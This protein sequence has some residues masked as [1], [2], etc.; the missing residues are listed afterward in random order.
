MQIVIPTR[1]RTNQQLTLQS[2]PRELLKQTTVVCPKNEAVSLY[3]LYND[4]QIVVQPDANW[5]IARK[6]AWIMRTWLAAGYDKIL[7]FDDDLTFATRITEGDWHLR[8]IQGEEL[9]AEIQRLEQKLGPAFPHV[10]FGQRQGNNNVASG[11]Q[12]PARMMYSLGY[13][14]PIVINECE[15]G[16]IETRE[17]MDITLQLLRKG[18]PN[19]VW[20]TTVS[21]QKY[22]APGGAT[23]ERTIERSNADAYKLARLHRG[24]VRVAEKA[25]TSMPRKEVVVQWQKALRD[26]QQRQKSWLSS[27][28]IQ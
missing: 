21:D 27:I 8:E 5:T 1:G 10:G 2:L 26:G 15:L 9:G 7:M 17:D 3:R 12:T 20:N 6:R 19:A 24:Y 13:F 28:I 23:N 16:R 4:V 25:Y 18:Y 14:L 11:W 22:N